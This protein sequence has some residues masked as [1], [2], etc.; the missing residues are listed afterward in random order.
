MSHSGGQLFH[1]SSI[2]LFLASD[3]QN[4][5]L[6]RGRANEKVLVFMSVELS[7]F[8]WSECQHTRKV[9]IFLFQAITL[10]NF[11]SFLDLK[12]NWLYKTLKNHSTWGSEKWRDAICSK[13]AEFESHLR[14]WLDIIQLLFNLQTC[15]SQP[16]QNRSQNILAA[17]CIL[18]THFLK[19]FQQ[20]LKDEV[21]NNKQQERLTIVTCF[22]MFVRKWMHFFY[23]LLKKTKCY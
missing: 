3:E 8:C 15:I 16:F 10:Q 20:N 7:N 6:L 2:L 13:A 9:C 17:F 12:T 22:D 14:C 19:L 18:K 1:I 11:S 5:Q 21:I 23:F 4:T